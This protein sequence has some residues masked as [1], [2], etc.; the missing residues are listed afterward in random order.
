MTHAMAFSESAM[1]NQNLVQ[2]YLNVF[3][4]SYP[5]STG[6]DPYVHKSPETELIQNP[7]T[8]GMTEQ[9]RLCSMELFRPSIYEPNE[10]IR[11]KIYWWTIS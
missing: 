8:L 2:F 11:N 4:V 1:S 7:S 3:A 6:S 10:P 9:S 5:Y